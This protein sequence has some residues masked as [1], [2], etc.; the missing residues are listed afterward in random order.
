MKKMQEVQP[1]MAELREKYKNDP[2][3]LNT[4]VVQLYRTHNI[5]PLAGCLPMLLQMPVFI[6]LYQVLWRTHNFEGAQFLW[7]KDLSLPDK[8]FVFNGNLPFIGNEINILPVFM[9]I[10]MFFQQKMSSKTMVVTD[11][12]QEMQQ[13]MMMYIFPIFIGGIF[14]HFASGLTLYFT[15]FYLLSTLTQYKMSKYTPAKK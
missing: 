15:V 13:K 5:N 4:E 12:S 7:I 1:K 14:Y 6:S 8:L 11:P 10:V 3:K 9:T 2:Q